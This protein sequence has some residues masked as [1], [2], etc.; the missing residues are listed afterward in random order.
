MPVT[1]PV[2]WF[3]LHVLTCNTTLT[4]SSTPRWLAR[5]AEWS[6]ASRAAQLHATHGPNVDL[7]SRNSGGMALTISS[8]AEYTSYFSRGPLI[9]P[10]IHSLPSFSQLP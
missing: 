1:V 6:Q 5:D 4:P 10:L 9:K 8:L 7:G 3:L 2:S